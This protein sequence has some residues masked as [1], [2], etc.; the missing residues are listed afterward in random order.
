MANIYLQTCSATEAG[1][2]WVAMT[3]GRIALAASSPREC[4]FS[5]PSPL[6]DMASAV[7]DQRAF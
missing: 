2:Q 4:P 6:A 7:H 5:S 1:Q 3:D